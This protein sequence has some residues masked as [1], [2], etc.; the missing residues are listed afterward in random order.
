MRKDPGMV[1]RIVNFYLAFDLTFYLAVFWHSFWQFIWQPI[2]HHTW[3]SLWY[4][5]FAVASSS[6]GQMITEVEGSIWHWF[7]ADLV[8]LG[9]R[10]WVCADVKFG[11]LLTYIFLSWGISRY[12]LS[13][14]AIRWQ[15]P[16]LVL[17]KHRCQAIYL[18]RVCGW[19]GRG[20]SN[21]CGF[22]PGG[23]LPVPAPTCAASG[24]LHMLN[25]TLAPGRT[26]VMGWFGKMYL[27][28][29]ERIYI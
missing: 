23:R 2:W 27:D 18:A 6:S 24:D 8:M 10:Y 22:G 26:V 20:I 9:S 12:I 28:E 5:L 15:T 13:D 14:T 16:G 25:I 3:H 17:G 29:G 4:G 11:P 21:K 7:G 19:S 1:E